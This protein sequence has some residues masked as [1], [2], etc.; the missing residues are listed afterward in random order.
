MKSLFA[1]IGSKPFFFFFFDTNRGSP[2]LQNKK[3]FIAKQEAF[4]AKWENLS[5]CCSKEPT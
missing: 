1:F 5:N 2:L 3:S 4:T